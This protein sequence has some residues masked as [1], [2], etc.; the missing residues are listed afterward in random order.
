MKGDK[1]WV[2]YWPCINHKQTMLPLSSSK[3]RDEEFLNGGGGGGLD[4]GAVPSRDEKSIPITYLITQCEGKYLEEKRCS[5]IVDHRKSLR[6][7]ISP[8]KDCIFHMST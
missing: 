2:D 1:R 4:M 7:D 8:L 3:D 6:S 5:I